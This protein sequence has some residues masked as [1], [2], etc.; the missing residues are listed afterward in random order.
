MADIPFSDLPALATLA[1]TEI[2]PVDN[3]ATFKVTAQQVAALAPVQDHNALLNLTAGDAHPQYHNNAR[4]DARYPLRTL[5]LTAG[6]GITG[7]GDLSADRTFTVN[8][9]AGWGLSVA[10]TG[11]QFDLAAIGDLPESIDSANDRLVMY[12]ASESGGRPRLVSFATAIGAGSGFVAT[13][14]Q[15]ISGNGLTGGGDLSAD[16]T[17]AVGAGTGIIVN[18]DDVALDTAHARNVDHSAISVLSGTGLTGGGTITTN[19]TLALDTTSARN[20]D[21]AAVAVLAGTGLTGGG[22]LTASRTL[23][24][25]TTVVPRL[26]SDN[27]FT[28]RNI[29]GAVVSGSAGTE[30]NSALPGYWLVESDVAANNTTWRTSVNGSAWAIGILPDNRA[31]VVNA[32]TVSRNLQTVTAINFAANS[33][34]FNG[35]AMTDAAILTA[36][37]LNNARVALSNVAQHQASLSIGW[38]Q[39][40][41]TK[42]ADQLQGLVTSA[43][44]QAANGIIRNDVN[45]FTQVRVLQNTASGTQDGLYLGY[46]NANSGITRLYGGGSTTNN[47]TIDAAGN[48]V[49][50]GNVSGFSDARLKTDVSTIENALKIVTGLRGVR[51][52]RKGDQTIQVGLIAQ[53]VMSVL[54]EVVGVDSETEYLHIAYGNVVGV[55]V[56]AIK[57]LKHR[58]EVLES[59]R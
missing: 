14:R 5:V 59:Q 11:V 57:E 28:A 43:N 10:P 24:I 54:P 58:V 47:V 30:F 19:R 27:S 18:A 23:S 33:I 16:R 52:R 26:G 53:E 56:E 31:S 7:G 17:L 40:T 35:V 50:S 2:L 20:T 21:H 42:N 6:N 25:D 48:V 9:R 3:G 22:D 44:G 39:I 13:S 32:I 36:G 41:G 4:G 29:F 38:S 49:A 37:T 46:G 45:G 12:N 15:I 51:F 55:L 1:G 34:A 8:P